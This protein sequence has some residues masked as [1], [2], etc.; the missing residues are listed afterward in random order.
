MCNLVLITN[1]QF[2]LLTWEYIY[3]P[4][5]RDHFTNTRNIFCKQQKIKL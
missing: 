1:F 3:T 5:L 4:M 2:E